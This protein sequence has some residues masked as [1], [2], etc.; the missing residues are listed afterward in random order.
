MDL[1]LIAIL[2]PT[3][4]GKTA[5]GI[6]L[7]ERLKGEIISCDSA[8]VYRGLNIGTA[9]PTAVERSRAPFHLLNVVAPDD[10]YDVATFKRCAEAAIVE[11][12]SRRHVPLLVGGTG[13]Y[14]KALLDNY[15]LAA[16]PSI[17]VRTR[18]ERMAD[19]DLPAL[20]R[21]LQELDPAAGARIHPNDRRRIV[22]A[23]EVYE[24]TGHPLTH[25]QRR[26]K[27]AS[28]R[29]DAVR[30]GL[31]M[32]RE[33]LYRR[34]EERVERMMAA[35]L[36]EEAL[37]LLNLGYSDRCAGLQA[38]GYRQVCDA[39]AGR[40]DWES[41]AAEITKETRQFAKRQMTWFRAD[42]QIKWIDAFGKT[43]DTIADEIIG[44]INRTCYQS[45][46]PKSEEANAQ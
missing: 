15:S 39:I 38:L 4:V 5:V 31:T 2:G 22:R 11:I 30:F 8:Q 25:L 13:L 12:R 46:A 19:Q 26:A 1:P 6:L 34:I 20:H 35:G 7:A 24:A 36:V 44:Q 28:E 32:P 17:E 29:I 18:I 42:S 9:K 41:L 40:L 43:A 23:L 27:T 33:H 21:R 10:P 14:A 45:Q 16:A 37:S 3:A